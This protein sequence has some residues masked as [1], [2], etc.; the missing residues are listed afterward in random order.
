M[1]R[2]HTENQLYWLPGRSSKVC[3]VGG[4][5]ANLVIDFGLALAYAWPSQTKTK[6][7]NDYKNED[8]YGI[9]KY[10]G[11]L[12]QAP[13]LLAE[14]CFIITLEPPTHHPPTR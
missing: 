9:T 8:I 4:L 6:T 11:K 12:S 1:V 3:V 7:I 10:I 13:A 14:C 5:G 2:L